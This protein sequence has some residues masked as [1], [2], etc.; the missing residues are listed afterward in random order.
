[1]V[2]Y[3]DQMKTRRCN[4]LAIRQMFLKFRIIEDKKAMGRDNPGFEIGRLSGAIACSSQKKE[5]MLASLLK[6][7]LN[8]ERY[9]E[10][11]HEVDQHGD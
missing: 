3:L 9:V 1:M 6:G 7:K 11:P 5:V 8:V 4:P 2:R 10:D